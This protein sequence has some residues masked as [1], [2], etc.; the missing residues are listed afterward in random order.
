MPGDNAPHAGDQVHAEALDVELL[1]VSGSWAA[2][3]S[4]DG[5]H[6]AYISDRTGLPQLW[7][8][9]LALGAPARH[10]PLGAPSADPASDSATA[11]AADPVDSV[12]SVDPVDPVVQVRWSADGAWLAVAVAPGGGVKTHVWAVRPDGSDARRLAGAVGEH[13][14]MGPWSPRGSHLV[15]AEQAETAAADEVCELVDPV[16]GVRRELARGR[17]VT[18]LGMSLTE[19]FAL[20]RDGP[21]GAR[22]PVVLDRSIDAHHP[23]LPFPRAGSTEDGLLRPPPERVSVADDDSAVAYL[24]S[25]S[26]MP[27]SA[28]LAVG[29]RADG[30]RGPV[31]MI[32]GRPD[33][34]LERIDADQA[35]SIVALLWNCGGRS[36]LQLLD[37]RTGARRDVDPLP[38]EVASSLTMSADGTVVVAALESPTQPREIWILD[39]ASGAWRRLSYSN[40]DQS[41]GDPDDGGARALVEPTLEQ[42]ESHDGLMITGWL[43]RAAGDSGKA[44][45]W[46]HGGPEA[47]ERPTFSPLFQSIV[48][49]GV[50]LFAPNVRGST[51]Y[52]RMFGHAD[53]LSGRYSA[54]ADVAMCARHLMDIGVAL[55]ESIACSGRSYGGYLTLAAMVRYPWIFAAGID[56]CG[57]SDLLTFYRDTEPWIAAAA[58]TKYGDPVR[59]RALLADLSPLARISALRAPMLVVHGQ[60]DTNVPYSEATQLVA[61]L[62][63]LGTPV[64]LLSFADEGHEYRRERS[65]IAQADAIVRFLARTLPGRVG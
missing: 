45:I 19:R 47:Q 15:V 25:D 16:T 26:G 9:A 53:D 2:A 43:Y 23:L 27:R 42:F 44:M 28:L 64:E 4:P 57:M 10:L 22:F 41:H 12:D 14:A 35:G 8:Q 49:S 55:A 36:E 7:V 62:E 30:Q 40:G 63:A 31:G 65:R 21:R 5:R 33:A 18:V 13:V 20:L 54:I 50:S 29:I 17:R 48:R 38:G 46:L 56:I 59:D 34:D 39:V 37:P 58:V 1:R 52:G 61:A 60:L 24:I 32:A 6:A 51:G 3:L 11:S